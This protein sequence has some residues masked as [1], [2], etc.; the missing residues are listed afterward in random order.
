MGKSQSDKGGI[1]ESLDNSSVEY[2]LLE[3]PASSSRAGS[4]RHGGGRSTA[5]TDEI[6]SPIS[7]RDSS[8]ASFHHE[9]S[10]INAA[11]TERIYFDDN[12]GDDDDDDEETL[13]LRSA[14][15]GESLVLTSPRPR[16]RSSF[17]SR[18]RR[19]VSSELSGLNYLNLTAYAAHVFVWYG[20]AVAG[21]LGPPT[22][23][24]SRTEQYET[25]VT[26]TDWAARYLWIPI[27][28]AQGGF[29]LA[30]LLP[31][32][33]TRPIL[34]T[35]TG[36]F[37]FYTVICQIAYTFLYSFGVFIFSFVAV[38]GTAVALLS[39]LMS[40]HH[41]YQQHGNYAGN[42]ISEYLL[43]RLPFYLHTGWV[44]I[45]TVDHFALLF[46]RYSPDDTSLQLAV[47]VV[48][49][50]VLLPVSIT[51]LT[52]AHDFVIP[53]VSLW[54]YVSTAYNLHMFFG[55]LPC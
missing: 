20:I 53:L 5:T 42:R 35:G 4:S 10:R 22:T 46:R 28:L 12:Q 44:L 33:R 7:H 51:A 1:P 41:H 32:Y 14:N 11:Q 19:N 30:Q 36:Y 25:L 21:W 43:F 6:L 52:Q 47:D 40:Q 26:P 34:T 2:F 17:S 13:T 27:L 16:I 18:S 54:S 29:A 49:L 31:H 55:R 15:F 50:A 23:R 48:A 37:F 24:W 39:L 38:V 9:H 8:V 45:M 3:P